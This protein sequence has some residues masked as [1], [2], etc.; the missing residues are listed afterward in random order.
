MEV[1]KSNVTVMNQ[2]EYY[3][4]Y[5]DNQYGVNIYVI[6]NLTSTNNSSVMQNYNSIVTSNQA[7]AQKQN[8]SNYSYN[9]SDSLKQYTYLTNYSNKN[10]FIVTK[11]KEDMLQILS[12]IHVDP[13]S[14]K[15]E[16][17]TTE[18]QTTSKSTAKKST[19]KS[20]SSSSSSS[21]SSKP[22]DTVNGGVKDLGGDYYQTADGKVHY[23]AKMYDHPGDSRYYHAYYN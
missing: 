23:G 11:N 4:F 5:D 9:Y 8:N 1:P 2:T 3:Y 13:K 22:K 21:S 20:K 7:G 18:N 12:T 6:D 17:N 19:S 16:T 15:N 14:I 10:V